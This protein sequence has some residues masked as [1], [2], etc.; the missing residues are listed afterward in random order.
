LDKILA[1]LPHWASKS[2]SFA[3]RLQFDFFGPLQH[4]EIKNQNSTQITKKNFPNLYLPY[5]ASI[6]T[7]N[8]HIKL[9]L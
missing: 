4:P 1:R 9:L 8:H 3:G 2:S 5:H 7:K 6:K